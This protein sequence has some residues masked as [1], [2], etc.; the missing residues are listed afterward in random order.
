MCGDS[1]DALYKSPMIQALRKRKYEVALLDQPIDEFAINNLTEFEG[2][3]L[4]NVSKGD[5]KFGDETEIE[6]KKEKQM[7]KDFDPLTKWM[8]EV[9]GNEVERVTLSKR[10]VDEPCVVTTDD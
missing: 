1:R 8:K 2:T 3:K 9:L 10:L 6:R 5:L 4:K 7:N